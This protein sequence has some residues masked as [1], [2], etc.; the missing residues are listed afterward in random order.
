[1]MMMIQ[2]VV[3]KLLIGMQMHQDM[4]MRLRNGS[5]NIILQN[6]CVNHKNYDNN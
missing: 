2:I 1:M 5:G 3:E 6:L 4:N